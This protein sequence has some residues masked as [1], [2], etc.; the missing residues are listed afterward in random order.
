MSANRTVTVR[1]QLTPGYEDISA[2]H[3][4]EQLADVLIDNL[5]GWFAKDIRVEVEEV[6]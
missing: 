4:Q 2:A 1:L 3:L 5:R 6:Q